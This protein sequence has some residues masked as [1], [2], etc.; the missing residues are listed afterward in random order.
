LDIDLRE[1]L[2]DAKINCVQWRG[3]VTS[4]LCAEGAPIFTAQA[5]ARRSADPSNEA[6]R[7]P[8]NGGS[9]SARDFARD[10][11]VKLKDKDYG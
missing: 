1:R 10:D 11:N 5:K 6:P 9:K 8:K 7:R 3:R 2:R 4:S